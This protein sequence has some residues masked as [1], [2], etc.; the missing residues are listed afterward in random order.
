MYTFSLSFLVKPRIDRTNMTTKT[1]KVGGRIELNVAVTGEPAPDTVWTLMGVEVATTGNITIANEPYTTRFLVENGTRK[2]SQRYKLTATNIHGKDEEFVELVFLGRPSAPMGPLEVYGVTKDSCK[3]NWRPPEDDGGMPIKEYLVEKM[4][5]ETGKWVA[6]CRTPP[7]T[8][9]CPVK[10]LQE[11][12]EYLF[13]VKA[14]NEEGESEPLTADKAIKAKDPFG[15][16]TSSDASPFPREGE[17]RFWRAAWSGCGA[18]L[19]RL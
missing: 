11:G 1:A 16:G 9:N 18:G 12:H 17:N 15:R 2:N 5:K 6:V 13:R 7:D 19:Q 14:I 10:G 8:T 3:L 4:D